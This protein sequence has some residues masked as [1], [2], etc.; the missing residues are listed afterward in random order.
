M[1]LGRRTATA[2]VKMSSRRR[3]GSAALAVSLCA[4]VAVLV[5][6]SQAGSAFTIMATGFGSA[7]NGRL[8]SSKA[9]AWSAQPHGT[10]T[11]ASERL[12]PSL[13]ASGA[14]AALVLAAASVASAS[15]R[16]AAAPKALPK[17]VALARPLPWAA[18]SQARVY[19][20]SP[21]V[22]KSF[23]RP[24]VSTN[25]IDVS[26]SPLPEQQQQLQPQQPQQLSSTPCLSVEMPQAL[27]QT[28]AA[29]ANSS[30]ASST[31][32]AGASTSASVTAASEHSSRRRARALDRSSPW[33][34]RRLRRAARA[35][36]S[37]SHSCGSNQEREERR[38]TGAK[39][40][41]RATYPEVQQLSFDPSRLRKEMQRGLLNARSSRT[42]CK[43]REVCIKVVSSCGT[44]TGDLRE[45][46][47][48]GC[49]MARLVSM[50][51]ARVLVYQL[52]LSCCF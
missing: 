4:V 16:R 11:A 42:K 34:P 12:M 22:V 40:L 14:A 7:M 32:V 43:Q 45:E 8:A 1:L 44:C 29:A 25:L 13:L 5:I 36:S 20:A 24:T 33:S 31:F 49:S 2:V 51:S 41:E 15:A 19:P 35:A 50:N 47:R 17:V 46:L 10:S 39:L 37:F 6:V 52:G 9:G 18:S 3:G 30:S 48:V 38:A 27:R 28:A 23:A 21:P 26:A